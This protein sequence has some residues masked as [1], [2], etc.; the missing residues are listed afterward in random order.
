MKFFGDNPISPRLYL[1]LAAITALACMMTSYAQD[2]SPLDVIPYEDKVR[3]FSL[4]DLNGV[5]HHSKNYRGKALL[6]VFW[7]VDCQQCQVDISELEIAYQQ[8]KGDRLDIIAIHA[9]DQLEKVKKLPGIQSAHY[10]I[11]MDME[12]GLKDWGV[13]AIPAAYLID[14]DGYRRY[15][16]VG[17]RD[18]SS[19]SMIN[20]LKEFA[21]RYG[22]S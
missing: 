2:K 14:A 11:L 15:R 5:I 6:V 20:A 21:Q 13:P 1:A 10:T 7:T 22:D 12:L 4:H 8:L 17:A 18:W 16:A 19:A 3:D 9:G